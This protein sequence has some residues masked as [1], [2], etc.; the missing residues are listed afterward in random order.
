M[1][2]Y[3]AASG[4]RTNVDGRVLVMERTFHAPQSLLFQAYSDSKQLS[5]WWGPQGWETENRT[6]EFKPGGTWLYC[7]RCMDKAQGDFY[8]QESWGKATFNEIVEPEKIVYTD[9]FADEKG[10]AVEGMPKMEITIEFKEKEG[11]SKLVVIS[12][13]A[14]EAQLKEVLGMG[15]IEGF[16]S[17]LDRLDEHLEK[18]Q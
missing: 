8:G 3:E 18:H 10:N 13:F 2:E 12:E 4:L 1:S 9:V 7:M 5:D 11:N 6:F 14:S 15:M 17:Q 16:N